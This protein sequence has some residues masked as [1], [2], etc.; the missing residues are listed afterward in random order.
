MFAAVAEHLNDG[1]LF[2]V[3]ANTVGELRRLGEEPPW[4]YEF[5][6]H[7]LIMDVS[8]ADGGPPR[9]GTSVSSNTWASPSTCSTTR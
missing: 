1:G 4:V 7:V 8:L 3:D 6:D 2:I 9:G 5:D